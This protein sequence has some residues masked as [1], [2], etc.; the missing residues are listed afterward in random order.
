MPVNCFRP[1]PD[2]YA[3]YYN[4]MDAVLLKKY[5]EEDLYN[6]L[7]WLL[8]AATHWAAYDELVDKKSRRSSGDFSLHFKVFVMDSA[9]LHARALY[10]FLTA[11]ST[12]NAD[13]LT[14]KDFGLA[15]GLIS[16]KYLPDFIKDLHGRSMHLNKNRSANN[17]IKGDVVEVAQDIL[18]LWDRFTPLV[19]DPILVTELDKARQL[20]V[21][22]ANSVAGNYA[23]DDFVP[24]FV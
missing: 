23:I 3:C 5:V 20:S 24:V 2:D 22:D 9:F 11:T 6:E 17:P 13:R 1:R 19:T 12:H 15:A 21:N 14:W 10:E 7:R 4:S 16:T 8:T 18:N